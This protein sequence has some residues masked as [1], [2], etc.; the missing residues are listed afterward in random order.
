MVME[1]GCRR[2]TYHRVLFLKEVRTLFLLQESWT[3]PAQARL[4]YISPRFLH[5]EYPSPLQLGYE[6]LLLGASAEWE[7][8]HS[9]LHPDAT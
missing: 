4:I 5:A 6:A 3:S 9:A 2:Y 8:T 1:K 7:R